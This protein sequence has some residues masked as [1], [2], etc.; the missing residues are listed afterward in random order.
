MQNDFL[1]VIPSYNRANKQVT[2]NYLN[3]IGV[4]K[5]RIYVFVQTKEDKQVYNET[6]GEKAII[7]YKNATR[8]V[9]ARNN[10]LNTLV[11]KYDLLMLDDDIKAIG[12]YN[13]EKID[14]ITDAKVM[15]ETFAKCFRVCNKANI[16]IFGIYPIY[17][18]FFLEKTISTKSPINT[19]FGFAKGFTGRYNENYDTKEDAEICAKILSMNRNIFRFNYLAVDADHRKTKDGYI[20]DWHQEENV[21]CVKKLLQDYPNIYKEQKNKPWEVR[22]IIKDKKIKLPGYVK[23]IC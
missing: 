9:E 6:I 18:Y 8:G 7:V 14:K 17:N 1:Y 15:D 19:V 4:P 11:D 5:E 22:T 13:G 20:D 3:G 12:E 23:K 2:V 21:R 16:K 10:I